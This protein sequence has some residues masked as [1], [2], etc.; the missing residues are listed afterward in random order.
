M[1]KVK[2]CGITSAHDARAAVV[3][4]ADA[5]GFVFAESPRRVSPEQ[6]RDILRALPSSR[7]V[8][9]GVF[10]DE[11][12]DRMIEMAEFVG[13]HVL[14]LHGD[15]PPDMVKELLAHGFD[16]VKSFRV[17]AEKDMV[18]LLSA[19]RPTALL[20]DTYVE[21]KRGGTGRTFDWQR[22]VE[23]KR[24]G[25]VILSG[26]LGVDN[27]VEA[28]RVASP[29]GVDA[30]SRLE[31]RPGVKDHERVREFIRLAKSR[32]SDAGADDSERE[33]WPR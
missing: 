8:P 10:V 1:T 24:F 11:S 9:V 15:E 28:V 29:Y 22:A 6:A 21:G 17:S 26:G 3:A 18:K 4:G 30:S 20:L 12:P 33:P 32:P 13:L 2:V 19:Y 5:I 14:Q 23:A 31:I 7:C 27:V 25:R 16:V